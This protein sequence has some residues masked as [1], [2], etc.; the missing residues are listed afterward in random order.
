VSDNEGF[1]R[2]LASWALVHEMLRPER[3]AEHM[4]AA[5]RAVLRELSS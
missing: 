2:F 4:P 3:L 5:L 1:M